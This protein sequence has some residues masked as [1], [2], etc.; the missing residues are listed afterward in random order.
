VSAAT[1][2]PAAFEYGALSRRAFV[3]VAVAVLAPFALFGWTEGPPDQ[4]RSIGYWLGNGALVMIFTGPS[5]WIAPRYGKLR[6]ILLIGSDV[7]TPVLGSLRGFAAFS[8]A[9]ECHALA[10][11]I[12][13][14]PNDGPMEQWREGGRRAVYPPTST[15]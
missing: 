11:G 6:G 5:C 2:D 4:V 9:L 12:P 3:F 14:P 15:T 1:D 13:F 8:A 10:T 7:E